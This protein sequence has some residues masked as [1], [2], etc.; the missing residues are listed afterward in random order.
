MFQVGGVCF[1]RRGERDECTALHNNGKVLEKNLKW[2][3]GKCENIQRYLIQRGF[4]NC[5]EVG[6]FFDKQVF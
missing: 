6:I 1:G 5:G 3:I 4:N 2:R